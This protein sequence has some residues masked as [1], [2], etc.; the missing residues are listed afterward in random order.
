M[1]RVNLKLLLQASCWCWEEKR[2][3]RLL[4]VYW[5]YPECLILSGI[6]SVYVTEDDTCHRCRR[7]EDFLNFI[8]LLFYV[9]FYVPRLLQLLLL[10]LNLITSVFRIKLYDHLKL[11][12]CGTNKYLWFTTYVTFAIISVICI[13]DSLMLNFILLIPVSFITWIM[14]WITSKTFVLCMKIVWY[15]CII[16]YRCVFWI[17]INELNEYLVSFD[18]TLKNST[19]L[20]NKIH[21]QFSLHLTLIQNLNLQNI[22]MNIIIFLFNTHLWLITKQSTD[23][24]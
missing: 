2:T 10:I 6:P 8:L 22:F 24:K 17:S 19:L 3:R 1:F 4:Y 18:I 9:Y 12:L 21:F 14:N 5:M 20:H 15:M 16:F 7:L 11:Q 13:Y 23:N